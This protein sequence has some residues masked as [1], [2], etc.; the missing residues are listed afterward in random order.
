MASFLEFVGAVGAV[1]GTGAAIIVLFEKLTG[2][3]GRWLQRNVTAATSDLEHYT[4]HHLGP[5]GDSTPVWVRIR[6]LED[7]LAQLR[8]AQA[9]PQHPMGPAQYPPPLPPAAPPM[10]PAQGNP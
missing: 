10:P 5:N 4:R 7:D 9:Y 3:T 8:A 1:V 2:I 6:Q